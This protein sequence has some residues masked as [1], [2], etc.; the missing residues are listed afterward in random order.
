MDQGKSLRWSRCRLAVSM[1]GRFVT[2]VTRATASET[3][4]GDYYCCASSSAQPE[5]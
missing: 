3:A 2:G 5:Y 1:P 4:G